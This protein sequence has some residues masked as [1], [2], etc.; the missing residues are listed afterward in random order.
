VFQEKARTHTLIERSNFRL[1]KDL[2]YYRKE[3][4]T[5]TEKIEKMKKEQADPYSIKKQVQ[6]HSP[7]KK[8]TTKFQNI[9][10]LSMSNESDIIT[11]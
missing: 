4:Q 11:Y 5:Q 7:S 1:G 6:A 8:R 2:E 3:E 9:F 10:V